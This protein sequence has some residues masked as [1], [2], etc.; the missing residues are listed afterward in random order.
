M[1]RTTD[2]GVE[3]AGFTGPVR[4]GRGPGPGTDGGC[5]TVGTVEAHETDHIYQTDH[6]SRATRW[7][8]APCRRAML[9]DGC[10]RVTVEDTAG[11]HAWT[12]PI[13]LRPDFV[14]SATQNLRHGPGPRNET[15]Y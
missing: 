1:V 4:V 14:S 2:D 9:G 13:R 5:R 3:V 6:S 12:N 10:C 15:P 7:P 8:K 11:G